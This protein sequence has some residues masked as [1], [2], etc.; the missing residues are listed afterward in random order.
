MSRQEYL[1]QLGAALADLVPAKEREDIL[2]YYE[3]YLDDAGPEREAEVMRELGSPQELARKIAREGGYQGAQAQGRSGWSR[4]IIPLGILCVVAVGIVIQLLVSNGRQNRN[5]GID[6]GSQTAPVIITMR[7]T[8]APDT[9]PGASVQAPSVL[10][11]TDVD[12]EVAMGDVTISEGEAFD[13]EL[14]WN[15]RLDYA[16]SYTV[17]GNTLTVT[18]SGRGAAAWTDGEHDCQVRITVPAGTALGEVEAETG[19]GDV[20]A[21][22]LAARALELETGL[23]DVTAQEV[24]VTGKLSLSSGLGDVSLLDAPLALETELETGLGDVQ[25]R[26]TS[27]EADCAYELSTGLG[28]VTI[29]SDGRTTKG[30]QSAQKRGGAC[31][32]EGSSGTG[33]VQV[34]FGG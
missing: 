11:F 31:E 21:A 6:A 4:R 29:H 34:Y 1:T 2:R 9:A 30:G 32:L 22:D 26:T 7:P 15:E 20:T 23:G 33:D 14:T 5:D 27:A 10:E 16:M 17:R 12:V 19:L 8:I 13:V 18:S 24:Q 25:V 28:E 3:E